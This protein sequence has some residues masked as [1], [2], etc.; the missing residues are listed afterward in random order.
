MDAFDPKILPPQKSSISSTPVL[1]VRGLLGLLLVVV[2]VFFVSRYTIK[3]FSKTSYKQDNRGVSVVSATV[4][5]MDVPVY[6]P[7]LGTVTPVNHITI[8]TQ[9][10]GQLLKVSFQEGQFIKKGDLLAEIDPRLYQ[11]QLFQ[12][13]GQLA[14]DQALL[15][16]AKLDLKRY[17]VLY[18]QDSISQ[19]TLNTQQSLVKQYTGN[20]KFDQGQIDSIKVN[21][22]YCKIIS[23]IEGLVGIKLID[24]GNFIQAAD[25]GLVVINTIQPITVVFSIPEDDLTNV[26]QEFKRNN[27]KTDAYDRSESKLLATGFLTVVDNQIDPSTGTI[28]L[29]AQFDNYD[30]RL[31]PNQF[32]NIKLLV[33]T[34]HDATV[35]PTSAIQYGKKGFFVYMLNADNTVSIQPISVRTTIGDYTAI[36]STVKPGHFVVIEGTDRLYDGAAVHIV[37]NKN[38]LIKG[39]GL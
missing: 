15:A 20:V 2:I 23:P 5:K 34:I 32:V 26:M 37:E 30:N 29:K 1:L 17:E 33:D 4:Q 7:A 18:E 6:L 16:N 35:V 24:P 27:L 38:D 19:Q 21:L 12:Y 36:T 25:S 3:L 28:K 31:F 13:E 8:K 10:S 9:T 22:N 39:L 11:A 14:R